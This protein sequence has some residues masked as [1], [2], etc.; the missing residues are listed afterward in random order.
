MQMVKGPISLRCNFALPLK[1][2]FHLEA[3]TLPGTSQYLRLATLYFLVGSQM[4]ELKTQRQ[5]ICWV[6]SSHIHFGIS[7]VPIQ[8]TLPVNVC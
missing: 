6:L 2:P 4:G 1:Y 8:S 5:E 3:V 7:S